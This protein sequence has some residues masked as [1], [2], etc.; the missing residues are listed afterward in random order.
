[1]TAVL[2]DI[3]TLIMA[4]IDPKTGLPFKLVS[5]DELMEP[6]RKT[7]RIKDE[8]IAV[9]RYKW[10]IM[11]KDI[12]GPMI[13]R[14]I[15]Y[16]GQ[17]VLLYEEDLKTFVFTPYALMGG[18]DYQ[19]RFMGI[20]PVP[21]A[22][23]EVADYSGKKVKMGQLNQKPYTPYYSVPEEGAEKKKDPCVI[24]F[25]YMNQFS[26]TNISRKDLM[27]PIITAEAEA[28][29]LARTALIANSGV[30][31]WR[32][33][34]ENEQSNVVMA[35]KSVYNCAMHGLPFVPIVAPIEFQDLTSAGSA[36][37][38]QEFFIYMQAVD[39]YRRSC[40]GLKNGGMFDKKAHKNESED[41]VNSSS[42]D[43]SME[44]GLYQRKKF[45]EIANALFADKGLKM[46]V[47]INEAAMSEPDEPEYE[48]TANNQEGGA[49]NEL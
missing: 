43:L 24:L 19:G 7:L 49:E 15:Y 34:N 26:Q 6:V 41:E 42:S 39:N 32:V 21:M 14:I 48:S 17:A 37:K 20:T 4:G 44:D 25:D 16:K 30:K 11:P 28:I 10:D 29:P 18:I 33:N 23:T 12:D 9:H 8:Q 27:D 22:S 13:E 1:M 36:M 45:C 3:Q 31:A 5:P 40:Y 46:S 2:P 38:A 47:E 35:N